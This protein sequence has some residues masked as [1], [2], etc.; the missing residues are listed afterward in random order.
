M[1]HRGSHTIFQTNIIFIRHNQ[2]IDNYLDIM[3]LITI[4]LHAGQCLTYLTVYTYIEISFFAY[5][6]EQ[7]FIMSFT[8]TYQW[9]ENINLL[10]L[11]I[12]QNKIENLLFSVLHHSLTR[13]I[14][15]GYTGTCIKQTQIIINFRCCADCR[16]GILIRRFLF[17]R[18]NRT[19][20]RNLIDIGTLQI[21]Q[22]IT[23]IRRKGFDIPTLSFGKNRVERQRRLAAS[24]QSR[25]NGKT[26]TG[27][28][29][30]DI[31]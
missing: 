5:L 17:N 13:K 14:R 28:F 19:Q 23:G 27:N 2:F 7:F 6:L 30:I 22:E 1:L 21:S 25:N 4:Q 9:G 10:A 11:I 29:R 18:N 20:S 12:F 16:T 3:V 8:S 24:A 26:V 31:F 15:I